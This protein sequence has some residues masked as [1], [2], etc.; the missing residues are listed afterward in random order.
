M[1]AETIEPDLWVP[2]CL[3]DTVPSKLF[4]SGGVAILTESCDN[5]FLLPGGEKVGVYGIVV[6]EEVRGDGDNGC[7]NTLL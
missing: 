4:I 2:Y 6:D 5:M 1:E 7:Q 3:S